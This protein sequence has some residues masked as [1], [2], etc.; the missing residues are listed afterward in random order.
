M[1]YGRPGHSEDFRG[2]IKARAHPQPAV[3]SKMR[4][5]LRKLLR[6]FAEDGAN[7]VIL[8][9]TEL[10]LVMSDGGS[11][12]V[13]LIDPLEVAAASAIKIAAGIVPLPT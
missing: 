2:G 11:K 12:D 4:A 7:T 5:T 10:C 9:C 13:L 1:I 3:R 8:G 6:W